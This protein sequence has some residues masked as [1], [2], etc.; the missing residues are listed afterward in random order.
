MTV[1]QRDNTDNAE[2][3]ERF[4]ATLEG[5]QKLAGVDLDADSLADLLADAM[6]WADA[7][8][9]DYDEIHQRAETYYSYEAE[10][11]G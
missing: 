5:Y 9:I 6:H 10:R 11:E 8:N 1:R 7:V 4:Y 3:A 2:R